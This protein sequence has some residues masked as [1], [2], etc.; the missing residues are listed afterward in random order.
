MSDILR[1]AQLILMASSPGRVRAELTGRTAFSALLGAHVPDSWPPGEYDRDAQHFFQEQHAAMGDAGAGWFG[2][3]AIRD[4]TDDTPRTVVACGGYF[5]PPGD[6]GAVE[7]GYSVCPE[8]TGRG[9]ATEIAQA[10]AA[11]ALQRPGVTLVQAHTSPDN[12]ASI[13]VLERSGF[14]NTG[15]GVQPDTLRFV[16]TAP[17][18]GRT[19]VIVSWSGGKDSTLMLERLLADPA[20]HV[21]ALLTTV[22]TAYDRVS[23]H[24]VRRSILR[25]QADALQLPLHEVALKATSSNAQYQAAFATV[26]RS[27]EQRYPDARTMAFGDLFLA[28]VRQYRERMLGELGWT[29]RYPLWLEPTR[30]LAEYFVLRGYAAVLTCV[31]TTQLDASFAGRS[32]DAALLASLPPSVD[33]CGERGEFHTCVLAGPIFHAPISVTL[34]ERV[35]RDERFQYCDLLHFPHPA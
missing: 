28:D 12:P 14:A 24:G 26:V 20:V 32:Y 33:P 16:R 19:Q 3:Y 22:S 1:T 13:A 8:W 25:A 9:F 17:Q 5:G 2:W 6:D 30:A 10:L 29:G 18:P 7:I 31:D 15:P 27:L 4:A 23:I 34:G 21:V 35:L 11:H